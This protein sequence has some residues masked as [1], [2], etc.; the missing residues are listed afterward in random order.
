MRKFCLQG[1]LTDYVF[2]L[3]R[4]DC[5]NR[6]CN[7]T[8]GT[9]NSESCQ[10]CHDLEKCFNKVVRIFKSGGF[11]R[12][13]IT[14]NQTL[15]SFFEIPS[16]FFGIQY[17]VINSFSKNGKYLIVWTNAF[18]RVLCSIHTKCSTFSCSFVQDCVTSK[19]HQCGCFC[20]T[21]WQ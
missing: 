18:R 10:K 17:R 1:G 20:F 9:T 2:M 11:L 8:Q 3:Q 15:K 14:S 19:Y 16:S 4:V 12:G 6:Q 13:H 21:P 7:Y 5:T